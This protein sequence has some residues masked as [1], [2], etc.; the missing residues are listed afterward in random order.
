MISSVSSN[1]E[2]K[3]AKTKNSVEKQRLDK[4]TKKRYKETEN[5]VAGRSKP[6]YQHV[7]ATP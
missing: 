6:V 4:Q 3:Q 7:Q 1:N 2:G 5:S